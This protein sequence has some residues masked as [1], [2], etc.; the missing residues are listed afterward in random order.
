[1]SHSQRHQAM[2]TEEAFLADIRANPEDDASRLIYADWLE[3]HGDPVRAEFIRLQCQLARVSPASRTS[4][5]VAALERREVQLWEEHRDEWAGPIEREHHV[6]VTMC[7]RG[8]PDS[9]SVNLADWGRSVRKRAD[10]LFATMPWT[11]V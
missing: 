2:N 7:R 11:A 9:V 10:A 4:S 3:D 5:R 1:M 6:S 8:F